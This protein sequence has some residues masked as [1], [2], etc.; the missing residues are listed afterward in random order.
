MAFSGK[1]L[2]SSGKAIQQSSL[3]QALGG[4]NCTTTAEDGSE[5]PC[6][7]YDKGDL[8]GFSSPSGYTVAEDGS[9]VRNSFYGKGTKGKGMT[10]A[11]DGS[12]VPKSY[13]D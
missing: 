8:G 10:M 5:V 3:A 7:F 11:E 4:A 9:V 12:W 1:G 13:Y 6:S 2:K